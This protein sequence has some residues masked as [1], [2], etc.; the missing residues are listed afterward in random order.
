MKKQTIFL[1]LGVFI[2]SLACQT[3][4]PTSRDGTVISGC[5]DIVTAVN[6]IQPTDIPQ[7]LLKTGVKQGDEFDVND[8]FK[9]LQ[10]ISMQ[11]GYSLDYVYQVDSLGAYPV[12]YALPDGQAPYAS[13][14][15]VPAN[16]QLADFRDHLDVQDVEDGY[17]EVVVMQIMARQFYLD[18]HANY[19]DAQ[20]VC[21]RK[22]ANGIISDVNAGDFGFKFDVA[23]QAKA[24]AMKN[25]EPVVQLTGNIATVEI[26]I[27]TKWGGFYRQTY[28]IS[29]SFP[30]TITDVREENL[31]PYDC[32]VAF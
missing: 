29:R 18:W 17:F 7:A 30:H 20:I 26:I 31:V 25:I 12:L 23:Q 24:R 3:L 1:L 32:G 13:F 27:F 14:A 9:V 2:A 15:D 16:T 5:S 19:N 4:I 21:N 8:Y 11:D 10:H 22:D 28:T 6:E